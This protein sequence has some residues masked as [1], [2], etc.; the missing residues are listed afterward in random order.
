LLCEMLVDWNRPVPSR[1]AGWCERG[2]G[3]SLPPISIV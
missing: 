2:G 1:H 3:A